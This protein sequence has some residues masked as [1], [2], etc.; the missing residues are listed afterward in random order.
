MNQDLLETTIPIKK[1][2]DF[3]QVFILLINWSFGKNKLTDSEIE[4][5]SY[6]MYY[7]NMYKDIKNYKIRWKLILSSSIKN[8]IKENFKINS[9]KFENYINKLKKK[10]IINNNELIPILNVYYQ[11]KFKVIFNLNF[12]EES[13]NLKENE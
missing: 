5:L 4:I 10:K 13:S 7:N 1:E 9:Q 12:L 2:L 11:P 3:Y 8:E 6:L